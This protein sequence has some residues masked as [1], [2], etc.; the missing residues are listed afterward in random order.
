MEKYHYTECGLDDVYLRNGFEYVD[1]DYGRAVSV[2]NAEELHL[3]IAGHI[4]SSTSDITGPQCRFLRVQMNLSQRELAK[5]FGLTDQAVAKWEK[6]E[7]HS[8]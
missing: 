2:R 4:V 8:V 7:P 5:L 1:T 6:G 3:I